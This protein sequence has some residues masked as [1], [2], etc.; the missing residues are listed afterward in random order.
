MWTGDVAQESKSTSEEASK[1]A[2]TRFA[3]AFLPPAEE[4]EYEPVSGG[5]ARSS[6]FAP[7]LALSF[8]P[9]LDDAVSIG[10]ETLAGAKNWFRGNSSDSGSSDEDEAGKERLRT[11]SRLG[12]ER[13]AEDGQ[14]RLDPAQIWNATS[15]SQVDEKN[16]TSCEITKKPELTYVSQSEGFAGLLAEHGREED[17]SDDEQQNASRT[18]RFS[19]LNAEDGVSFEDEGRPL[20][21]F[22]LNRRSQALHMSLSGSKSAGKITL[23]PPRLDLPTDLGLSS[24]DGKGKGKASSNDSDGS[25]GEGSNRAVRRLT[26]SLSH[27]IKTAL[28]SDTEIDEDDLPLA[29]R[30]DD[31]LPLG[32][33]HPVA[34]MSRQIE[35]QQQQNML[36]F[37]QMQLQHQMVQ[38]YQYEMHMQQMLA[39]QQGTLGHKS[40]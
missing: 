6:S 16:G 33:K 34:V 21:T 2:L 29:I 25:D 19:I 35:A 36:L 40:R 24:P 17:G 8:V 26:A 28:A 22:L 10:G 11:R 9:T 27:S 3:A 39:L 18:K 37:Q 12:L 31:E 13:D 4:D 5:R 20:S 23:D 30:Q 32:Q 14:E 38:Q 7:S 1:A 15:K